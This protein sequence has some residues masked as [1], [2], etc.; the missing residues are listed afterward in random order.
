ML[1]DLKTKIK[2]SKWMTQEKFAKACGIDESLIS[3]YVRGI[4]RPP[5]KHMEKIERMLSNGG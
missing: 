5:E 2:R 4:R 3:K 1:K